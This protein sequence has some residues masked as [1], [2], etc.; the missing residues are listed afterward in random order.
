MSYGSYC[1]Y[2]V[3]SNN[4]HPE[5]KDCGVVKS[6]SNDEVSIKHGSRTEL[7][8]NV[9]FEKTGFKS[10]LVDPTTYFSNDV[11]DYVCFNL[12]EKFNVWHGINFLMGAFIMVVGALFL[13]VM[14]FIYI[15]SED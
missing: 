8:L 1:V 7:Y 12:D 2:Y 6:K 13:V 15:F 3:L 10:V 4:A 5:Y 9:E 14:F 11:G